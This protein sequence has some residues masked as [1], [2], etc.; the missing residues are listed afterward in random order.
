MKILKNAFGIIGLVV[1]ALI[2]LV[3]LQPFYFSTI[4]KEAWC[5]FPAGPDDM[6]YQAIRHDMFDDEFK[7]VGGYYYS[8]AMYA[9][10]C[11]QEFSLAEVL[12]Y[13]I[14][15]KTRQEWDKSKRAEIKELVNQSHIQEVRVAFNKPDLQITFEKMVEEGEDLYYFYR[16]D[17]GYLVEINS[18]SGRI[19]S[20]DGE[21]HEKTEVLTD[22]ELEYLAKAYLQK[23]EPL[24]TFN[25]WTE[26]WQYH[27][28]DKKDTD[29]FFKWNSKQLKLT[30]GT[31]A[32]IQIGLD[33]Y[34]NLLNYINES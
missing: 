13:T 8:G 30:D 33:Q 19:E 18:F 1:V 23:I 6:L 15:P 29:I 24:F 2:F 34:G 7:D 5:Y 32:F 27:E 26:N 10:D 21:N 16:T 28:V 25:H 12:L 20:I 11:E 14:F 22:E 17:N 31:P 3:V 9:I 4:I